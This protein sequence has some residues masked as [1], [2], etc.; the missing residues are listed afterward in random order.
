MLSLSSPATLSPKAA[1]PPELRGDEASRG[2]EP[3]DGGDFAAVLTGVATA[4]DV[5]SEAG[6]TAPDLLDD[7]E[8]AT[9]TG[10]I[11][12]LP[13]KDGAPAPGSG[14]PPATDV[15]GAAILAALAPVPVLQAGQSAGQTAAPPSGSGTATATVLAGTPLAAALEKAPSG[16]ASSEVQTSTPARETIAVSIEARPSQDDGAGSPALA[17]QTQPATRDAQGAQA[18]GANAPVTGGAFAAIQAAAG[19][20]AGNADGRERPGSR[21][22]PERA[23][24]PLGTGDQPVDRSGALPQAFSGHVHAV[25]FGSDRGVEAHA[26]AGPS[27]PAGFTAAEAVANVVDRLF[28]A[29]TLAH[30]AS[31]RISLAHADFGPIDLTFSQSGKTLDVTV[32]AS[33]GETQSA[34]AAALQTA[35]RSAQRDNSQANTNAQSSAHGQRTTDA[36]TGGGSRDGQGQPASQEGD[37]ARTRASAVDSPTA[38]TAPPR[39]STRRDGIYA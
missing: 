9:G 22:L 15:T 28:E 5:A 25:T 17:A 35:D 2:R 30:H 24:M 3:E 32:S 20:A 23:T 38:D 33:S 31:A 1:L 10:N 39:P 36:S 16:S 18:P 21:T 7:T 37:K 26:I 29:R 11:L 14:T 27:T 8:T 13:G 19:S 34:L 4:E 6:S 12:P